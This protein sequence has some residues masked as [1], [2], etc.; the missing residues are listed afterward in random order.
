MGT[1][2]EIGLNVEALTGNLQQDLAIVNK[3]DIIVA[4]AERWD[5]ISRKWRQRKVI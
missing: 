4:T 2:S 5:M 3:A 1:K